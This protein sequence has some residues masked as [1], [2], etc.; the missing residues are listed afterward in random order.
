MKRKNIKR[1]MK[2]HHWLIVLC[3]TTVIAMYI[4]GMTK[5]YFPD[6]V[7]I[8]AGQYLDIATG[9]IIVSLLFSGFIIAII[10][11]KKRKVKIN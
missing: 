5:V 3:I 6:P 9:I 10:F 4:Y 2:K 7:H 8:G 11:K 1:K